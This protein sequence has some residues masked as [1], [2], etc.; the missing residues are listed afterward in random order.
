MKKIEDSRN[1]LDLRTTDFVRALGAEKH[2]ELSP[3]LKEIIRML[4]VIISTAARGDLDK[5]GLTY[6]SESPYIRLELRN[7]PKRVRNVMN[8]YQEFITEIDKMNCDL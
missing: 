1:N 8:A 2:W 7:V 3:D 5:L 6:T 4:L